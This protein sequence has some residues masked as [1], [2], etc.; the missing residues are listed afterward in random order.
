[1]SEHSLKP[2]TIKSY[3]DGK[4]KSICN[5]CP[6]MYRCKAYD[7]AKKVFYCSSNPKMSEQEKK[8]RISRIIT[9]S[10]EE[11]LCEEGQHESEK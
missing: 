4:H 1:M 8:K 10:V 11:T 7:R 3:I 9:K 2:T 6:H 5:S